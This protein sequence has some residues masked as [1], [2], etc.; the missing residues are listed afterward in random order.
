MIISE[1]SNIIFDHLDKANPLSSL[2]FL[3]FPAIKYEIAD[4]LLFLNQSSGSI[5]S[6]SLNE[7]LFSLS[8]I[9]KLKIKTFQPIIRKYL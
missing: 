7:G 5:S 1:F 8:Y 2:H 3:L 6:S 4:S 9:N